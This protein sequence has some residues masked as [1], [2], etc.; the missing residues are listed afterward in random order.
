MTDELLA[1]LDSEAAPDDLLG[2][3]VRVLGAALD[4]DRCVLFLRDPRSR[5]ARATHGWQSR[6]DYALARAD[7]GWREEPPALVHDDPMFAEALRNPAALFIEDVTTADPS[8]VN[9]PYELKHFRHRALVH[10][11]LYHHGLMYGI[12]EPSVMTEPR[13]WSPTDREIIATVQERIAPVA[14]EYVARNCR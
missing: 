8:L 11:P 2:D 4:C 10:A 14:A 3:L 13:A 5:R 6:P 1:L 7:Q 9:G 12:L